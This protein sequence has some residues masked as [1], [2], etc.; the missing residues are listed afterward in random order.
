MSSDRLEQLRAQRL[1][2]DSVEQDALMTIAQHLA[3]EERK[4]ATGPDGKP[5]RPKKAAK[6]AKLAESP[7][8]SHPAA[9]PGLASS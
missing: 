7:P 2:G 5:Q 1:Q 9:V 6:K 8:Q 3:D 4:N